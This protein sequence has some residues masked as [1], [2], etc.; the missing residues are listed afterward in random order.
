M[1][2]LFRTCRSVSLPLLALLTA[3]PLAACSSTPIAGTWTGRGTAATP[4]LSFG[5]VSFVGD[6]TFTAEAKYDGKTRVSNGV[7]SVAGDRLTLTSGDT[8]RVYT[9]SMVN[10]SLIVTDPAS[11]HST[12]LDRFKQ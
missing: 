10:G 1:L 2:S 5:S 11:G 9:Y 6:N 4:A 3:L 8:T 7:W 12:T